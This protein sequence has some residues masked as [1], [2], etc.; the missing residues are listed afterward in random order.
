MAGRYKSKLKWSD[1]TPR[2][3]YMN[4]RALMAGAGSLAIAGGLAPAVR[5]QDAAVEELVPNTWEEI[6]S[7]NNFYEFGTGKDDPKRNAGQ[8]TTD[9]WAIEVDG[10]VE[11]P[12]TYDIADVLA[13]KALEERIY[14]IRC[15]EAWRP[16]CTLS[17][18]P[19]RSAR[20]SGWW[21]RGNTGSSR[22]S[23]SC[24]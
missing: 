20:R 23:R 4:R 6:T 9:P 5:A 7:Y 22:S 1:V 2:A 17:R 3:D 18:C 19:I 8:M 16:G 14:R 13:D 21:C 11:R 12:G 10:L 15:V 24:G